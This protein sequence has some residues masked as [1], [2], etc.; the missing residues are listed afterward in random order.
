MNCAMPCAPA[1]L[2]V[3]VSKL[4]SCQIRLAK[5]GTGRLLACATEAAALQT[6]SRDGLRGGPTRRSSGFGV[7]IDSVK[8]ESSTESASPVGSVIFSITELGNGLTVWLSE[9]ANDDLAGEE[10]TVEARSSADA[11]EHKN[12]QAIESRFPIF[13][14]ASQAPVIWRPAPCC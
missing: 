7:G 1:R 8:S 12:A 5:N 2:M 13:T 11:P 4:L 14:R 10:E 9:Y 3:R 6:R